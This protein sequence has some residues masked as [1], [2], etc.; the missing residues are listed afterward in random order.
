MCPLCGQRKARRGCP[1]LGKQICAV[2]CG[3]KRLTEIR[4]PATCP[5]LT[6]AREHPPAVT[7]RQNL[8]DLTSF[9]RFVRDLNERQSRLFFLIVT[10][11]V[12]YE[13]PELQ[14]LI[15]EDVTQA[16]AALAATFET[17]SRGVIYEHRAPS[18]SAERVV[19]GLKPLL[20]E[21]GQTGGTA[22]QRDAGVVLRRIESAGRETTQDNPGHRRAFLEMLGRVIQQQES[23]ASASGPPDEVPRL[24]IP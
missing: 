7:V 16:M 11:L 20:T 18:L 1:A 2:C 9:V 8:H 4:C 22:F 6:V 21:A 24:I 5:Y 17:A 12:R 14:P 10:F 3:T 23:E 15:D 19:N 13:A